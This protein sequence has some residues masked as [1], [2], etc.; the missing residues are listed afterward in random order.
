MSGEFVVVLSACRLWSVPGWSRGGAFLF[1]IVK[2]MVVSSLGV[3]GLSSGSRGVWA[4][5]WIV[6]GGKMAMMAHSS[7]CGPSFPFRAFLIRG[8]SVDMPERRMG[9][10]S[11]RQVF[12]KAWIVSRVMLVC[13]CGLSR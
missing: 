9:F 10:F 4:H 8:E 5:S 11:V 6:C 12:V 2:R 13:V 3:C 1:C 7:L